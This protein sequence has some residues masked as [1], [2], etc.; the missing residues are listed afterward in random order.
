MRT[1][2]TV[3]IVFSLLIAAAAIGDRFGSFFQDRGIAFSGSLIPWGFWI[4]VGVASLVGGIALR[5]RGSMIK[6]HDDP[7]SVAK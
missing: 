1:V 5:R 6:S 7:H 3:L 2:G 4:A